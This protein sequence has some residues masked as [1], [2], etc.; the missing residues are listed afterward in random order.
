MFGFFKP[1]LAKDL[2]TADMPYVS[3]VAGAQVLEPAPAAM[4][5]VYL[6]LLALAVALGD[7]KSVV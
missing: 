2:Q 3:P 5:A 1:N 4:Y 6:M 7:R